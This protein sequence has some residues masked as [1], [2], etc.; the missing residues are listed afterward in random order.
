[1]NSRPRI[2]AFEELLRSDV[3]SIKLQIKIENSIGIDNL[4]IEIKG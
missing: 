2:R 1:V 3:L 4:S